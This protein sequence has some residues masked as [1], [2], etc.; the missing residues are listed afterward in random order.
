[1]LFGSLFTL[2]FLHRAV[3]EPVAALRL[4]KSVCTCSLFRAVLKYFPQHT[5]LLFP[6]TGKG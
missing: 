1:M 6:G 2:Q 4:F 5:I 3:K